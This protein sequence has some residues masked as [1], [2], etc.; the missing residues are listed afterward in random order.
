MAG[1]KD[2]RF[3]TELPLKLEGGAGVVRNVS[4]SGIYFVTDVALQ[5][6]QPVEFTLEFE[7]FPSSAIAV[8]CIARIVRVEQQGAR[9]GVAAAISSFEFHR[10][11]RPGKGSS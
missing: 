11:A 5:E 1:R 6:G 8:N 3:K 9:T 10:V 7:N 4:A 2:E